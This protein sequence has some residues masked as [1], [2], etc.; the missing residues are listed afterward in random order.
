MPTKTR[1][2]RSPARTYLP[3][4]HR[5]KRARMEETQD[6]GKLS[7]TM[8]GIYSSNFDSYSHSVLKGNSST[9]MEGTFTREDLERT[10][11][12]AS[13]ET[14]SQSIEK[15]PPSWAPAIRD[16]WAS[17]VNRMLKHTNEF[18]MK[19]IATRDYLQRMLDG[20]NVRPDEM[21]YLMQLPQNIQNYLARF[22]KL[23]D[24]ETRR[25]S[26]DSLN[27]LQR[28]SAAT[29]L[30]RAD[31]TPVR[32]LTSIPRSDTRR[33]VVK[34][35]Q[36]KQTTNPL[37]ENTSMNSTR[38]LSFNAAKL[39]KFEEKL[40]AKYENYRRAKELEKKKDQ[41][42]NKKFLKDLEIARKP[43]PL[44][45]MTKEQ[46]EEIV[47]AR[48]SAAVKG[49]IIARIEKYEITL[50]DFDTLRPGQWLNDEV[51]NAYLQMLLNRAKRETR[52]KVHIF[53]TF[54]YT[55]LATKGYDGVK[56][57]AR[58]A[59]ID[60]FEQ[61]LI[62]IPINQASHWFLAAIRLPDRLIEI[63]DSMPRTDATMTFDTIMYYL[64]QTHKDKTGQNLDKSQWSWIVET[65]PKQENGYDCGVFTCQFVE[66]LSRGGDLDFEQSDMQY[67]RQR[68]RYELI[69]GRLMR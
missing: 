52:R 13:E 34:K 32:Q 38:N 55:T 5:P 48:S 1:R 2:S 15:P 51:I 47:V 62:L 53:N 25:F 8:P 4:N 39:T 60:V 69:K 50:H 26:V 33:G 9:W 65:A 41:E 61:D 20:G 21:E 24:E 31:E 54:F 29:T 10:F 36:N 11:G 22:R 66:C 43:R 14:R 67:Y 23:T 40:Q 56:R 49:G 7:K 44:R 57:W 16:L 19:I 27:G 42:A 68:I 17:S 28:P 58:R 59:K 3:Y 12:R 46:L 37:T 6:V 63:Y 35:T 18:A 64:A 45:I 30:Q